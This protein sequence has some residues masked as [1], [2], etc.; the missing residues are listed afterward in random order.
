MI[1]DYRPRKRGI[2]RW[3]AM[4]TA[5]R[6]HG[7]IPEGAWAPSRNRPGRAYFAVGGTIKPAAVIAW[8]AE[9]ATG[10][11]ITQIHPRPRKPRR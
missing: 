10:Y 11:E 8:L 9:A 3:K 2:D 6:K 5:V 1:V 7:V 4:C